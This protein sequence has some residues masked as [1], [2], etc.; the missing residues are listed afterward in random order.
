MPPLNREEDHVM[1]CGSRPCWR[2]FA[3]VHGLGWTE[4]NMGEPGEFVIEKAF[5]ER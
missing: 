1:I 4:G 2:T 5:V 3:N